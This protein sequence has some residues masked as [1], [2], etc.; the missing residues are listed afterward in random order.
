M[1]PVKA[2]E[3]FDRALSLKD[4]TPDKCEC[5]VAPE[6]VEGH[7]V[8]FLPQQQDAPAESDAEA[9]EPHLTDA[10]REDTPPSRRPI[11]GTRRKEQQAHGFSDHRRARSGPDRAQGPRRRSTRS[12][13]EA[14]PDEIRAEWD[15]VNLEIEEK[16][17][18]IEELRAR[19]ERV[20]PRR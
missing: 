11:Y 15:Q 14:L 10:R 2:R 7:E 3:M 8:P 13:P 17:D 6:V 20:R 12:T 4:I 5:P 18:L 16:V 19:Q 9:T 1:D